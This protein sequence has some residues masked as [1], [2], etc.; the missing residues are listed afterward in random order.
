[1]KRMR[2][3]NI[4]VEVTNNSQPQTSA[5]APFNFS[6][7]GDR[8]EAEREFYIRPGEDPIDKIKHNLFVK[9]EVSKTSCYVNEPIVAT[10]KLYSRLRSESRVVKRPSYNGFSVYDMVDPDGSV[11]SREMLNGKEY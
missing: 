6:F 1:G 9:V 8:A 7:P 11:T 4:S 3:N 10:Y 5:P 2:S